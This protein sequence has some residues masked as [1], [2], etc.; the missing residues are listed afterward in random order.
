MNWYE[1]VKSFAAQFDEPRIPD[2]TLKIAGIEF[3]KVAHNSNGTLMVANKIVFESEFGENDDFAQ[4]IILRRLREEVLPHIE[5]DIGAE[6]VREFEVKLQT[7]DNPNKYENIMSKISIPYLPML[8][9]Y[10]DIF[11]RH[12]IPMKW[13]TCTAYGDGDIWTCDQNGFTHCYGN[14]HDVRGVRP[15]ICINPELLNN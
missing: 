6:N 2:I 12:I 15:I 1:F 9:R 11:R 4:S 3:V 14:P 7:T 10:E 13:W 5:A 8:N